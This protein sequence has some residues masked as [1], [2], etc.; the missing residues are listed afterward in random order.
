MMKRTGMEVAQYYT[1]FNYGP[2]RPQKQDESQY[3]MI[4]ARPGMKPEPKK[5]LGAVNKN[6]V[7]N[8]QQIR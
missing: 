7:N 2:P 5:S 8:P 6:M 3:R 1:V 4:V